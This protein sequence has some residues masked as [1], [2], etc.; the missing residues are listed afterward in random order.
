MKKS[1]L[2]VFCLTILYSF[3]QVV[4]ERANL[5]EVGL[6]QYVRMTN[7]ADINVGSAIAEA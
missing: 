7:S 3:S 6:K 4:I 2:F 1:F 5:P